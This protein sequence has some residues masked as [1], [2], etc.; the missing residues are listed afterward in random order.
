M[1]SVRSGHEFRDDVVP[2]APLFVT[3][4]VLHGVTF[5]NCT[6]VGPAVIVL[7]DGCEMNYTS[8][9]APGPDAFWEF[10]D[11]RAFLVGVL[12]FLE[13]RFIKCQLQ[14]IGIAAPKSRLPQ[15]LQGFGIP[16]A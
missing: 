4:D 10:P 5:T 2:L 7:L 6:L 16:S 9:D 3:N 15:L 14:R 8:L 1:Q 13:C 11:D 12:G